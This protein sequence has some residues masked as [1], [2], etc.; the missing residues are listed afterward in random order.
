MMTMPP[1]SE[2]VL[3]GP[4]TL[5]HAAGIRDRI[6]EALQ[7]NPNLALVIEGDD[8]SD[9]VDVSFVQILLSAQLSAR[10]AG[11][12]LRLRQEP[13]P[14]LARVIDDGGF[15]TVAGPWQQVTSG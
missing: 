9:D 1:E 7:A 12:V 6:H 5:R 4:L 8:E 11:G 10:V 2:L 13:G 15:A 14:A 3:R